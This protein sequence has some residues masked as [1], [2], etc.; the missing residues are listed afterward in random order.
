MTGARRQAPQALKQWCP[1]CQAA[2]RT[3][4]DTYF[5]SRERCARHEPPDQ[6]EQWDLDYQ[7]DDE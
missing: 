5:Q 4:I 3:W 6:R 1:V 2:T 7:E